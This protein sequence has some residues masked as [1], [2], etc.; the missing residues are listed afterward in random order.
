VLT[1]LPVRTSS[2]V[3]IISMRMLSS[4]NRLRSR[5]PASL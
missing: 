3:Q 1:I 5:L 2:P 4:I